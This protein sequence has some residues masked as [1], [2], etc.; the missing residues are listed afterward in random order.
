M[1]RIEISAR[2][3]EQTAERSVRASWPRALDWAL[4][5]ATP[6]IARVAATVDDAIGKVL[7]IY[8]FLGNQVHELK[9]VD[10]KL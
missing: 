9:S 7:L 1:L 2:L 4:H 10:R 5:A 6:G 3:T 8:A